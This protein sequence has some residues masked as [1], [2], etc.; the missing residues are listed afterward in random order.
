MYACA[1]THGYIQ[2]YP[3]NTSK[4]L[5]EQAISSVLQ[6][7]TGFLQEDQITKN[8]NESG[9]MTIFIESEGDKNQRDRRHK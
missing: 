9:Y 4:A 2:R 8:A 1:G 5:L 3:F 7:N 6:N